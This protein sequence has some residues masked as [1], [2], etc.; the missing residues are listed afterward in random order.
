[1]VT[2]VTMAQSSYQKVTL[3]YCDQAIDLLNILLVK[4]S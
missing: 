4:S 1:M 3:E 2:F